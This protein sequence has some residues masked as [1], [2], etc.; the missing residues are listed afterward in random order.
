MLARQCHCQPSLG[1]TYSLLR[2]C[3]HCPFDFRR[4]MCLSHC[5]GCSLSDNQHLPI[6]DKV[7][8]KHQACNDLTDFLQMIQ[9]LQTDHKLLDNLP[10]KHCNSKKKSMQYPALITAQSALHFTPGRPVHSNTNLIS[11]GSIQPH[12]NYCMKTICSHIHHCM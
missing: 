2:D 4:L 11:L 9:I 3:G 12:C 10:T 8:V 6:V 7:S 5:R 1:H